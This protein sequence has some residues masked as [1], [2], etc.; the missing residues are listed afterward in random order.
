[1]FGFLFSLKQLVAKLTPPGAKGGGFYACQ[2]SAYKLHYHEVA[3]GLRLV[4]CT[5][6]AAADLRE[7][8]RHIYANIFVESLVKNPLWQPEEPISSP[9]F[10]QQLE[11]YLNSLS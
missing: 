4:L 7:A 10:V 11:A 1:M 9:L 6:K 8:L 2:T 5:D 3:S